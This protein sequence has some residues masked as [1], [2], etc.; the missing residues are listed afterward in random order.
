MKLPIALIAMQTITQNAELLQEIVKKDIE[1]ML[2]NVLYAKEQIPEHALQQLVPDAKM[3]TLSQQLLLMLNSA[4][5]FVYH[6]LM[7]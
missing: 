4:Q 5:L 2:E 6:Q 7:F 1:K 3:V